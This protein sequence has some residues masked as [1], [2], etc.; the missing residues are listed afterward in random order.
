MPLL[1]SPETPV[2]KDHTADDKEKP[3]RGGIIYGFVNDEMKE[4][5]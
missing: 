2:L 1:F 3:H 5:H 4:Y